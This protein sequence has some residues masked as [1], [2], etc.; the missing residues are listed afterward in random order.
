MTEIK[1]PIE[2]A[3]RHAVHNRLLS[4]IYCALNYGVEPEYRKSFR[5][6]WR[7]RGSYNLAQLLLQC[8]RPDWS[9][10]PETFW[11]NSWIGELLRTCEPRDLCYFID[12]WLE[13]KP[14]P[15][16]VSDAPQDED[17]KVRELRK[18]FSALNR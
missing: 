9:S 7:E 16:F 8:A 11:I 18:L 10:Y 2:D 17:S 13:D 12:E 14:L 3:Y 1:S 6:D 5:K 4:S 15:P